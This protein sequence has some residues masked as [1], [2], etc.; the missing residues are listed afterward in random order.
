MSDRL[1]VISICCLELI[2]WGA[3]LRYRK[4]LARLNWWIQDEEDQVLYT[5]AIAVLALILVGGILIFVLVQSA[6]SLL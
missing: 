6:V 5:T 1:Q 2:F 4:R 3:I